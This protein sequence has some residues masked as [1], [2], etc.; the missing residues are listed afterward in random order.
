MRPRTV[1]RERFGEKVDLRLVPPG[2]P[3]IL[4][5]L[6][7]R[8]GFA[9]ESLIDPREALLAVEERALWARLGL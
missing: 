4:A 5:R 7:G 9:P 1:L 2:R 3:N 8:P 6:F